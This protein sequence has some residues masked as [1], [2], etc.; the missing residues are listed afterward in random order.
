MPLFSYSL[1]GLIVFIVN[2]FCDGYFVDC[3]FRKQFHAVYRDFVI[4]A[5]V[6]EKQ[7]NINDSLPG[8][9]HAGAVLSFVMSTS[10]CVCVCLSVCEDTCG[11][12]HDLYQFFVHVAYFR[13]SILLWRRCDTL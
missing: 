10:L 5:V 9:S 11:T 12:T 1:R 7:F 8:T 4:S 3:F 13:G 6:A 2:W